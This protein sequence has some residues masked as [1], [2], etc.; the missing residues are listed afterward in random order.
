MGET[1]KQLL[2]H[3]TSPHKMLLNEQLLALNLDVASADLCNVAYR[4]NQ[5]NTLYYSSHYWRVTARNSYTVKFRDVDGSA[6]YGQVQFFV[7]MSSH[8]FAFVVKLRVQPVMPS[9]FWYIPQ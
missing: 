7:C 1:A 4:V 6:Q 2:P 8:V 5:G 9:P 3:L